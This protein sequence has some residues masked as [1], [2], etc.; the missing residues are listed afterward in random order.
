MPDIS[1]N[2]TKMLEEIKHIREELGYQGVSV[3]DAMEI[4][5]MAHYVYGQTTTEEDV[6]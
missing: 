1:P 6:N 2:I 4:I 5:R 3:S